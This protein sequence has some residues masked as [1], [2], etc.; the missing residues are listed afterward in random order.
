MGG[1]MGVFALNHTLVSLRSVMFLTVSSHPFSEFLSVFSDMFEWLQVNSR[2]K[3][4]RKVQIDDSLTVQCSFCAYGNS[5]QYIAIL[6][7]NKTSILSS[8]MK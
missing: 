8:F 2:K 1:E 7:K 5:A 3:S 6:S 4:R